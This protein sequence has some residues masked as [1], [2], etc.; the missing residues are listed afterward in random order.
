MGRTGKPKHIHVIS[1]EWAD[2]NQ[3]ARSEMI[4][5]VVENLAGDRRVEEPVT[6]AM[7]LTTKGAH[8]LGMEAA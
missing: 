4:M 8:Q 3:T 6:V 2:L 5:D 7:G 1:D